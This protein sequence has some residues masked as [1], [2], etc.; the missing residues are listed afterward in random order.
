V[1]LR[2]AFP[3]NLEWRSLRQELRGGS[4]LDIP[5]RFY[6]NADEYGRNRINI[7]FDFR[8]NIGY[9]IFHRDRRFYFN[10]RFR[11]LHNLSVDF[12]R[13]VRKCS[14]LVCV[15]ILDEYCHKFCDHWDNYN[16]NNDYWR[17][18]FHYCNGDEF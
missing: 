1:D 17:G 9:D 12:N 5:P 3:F 8:L 10:E 14:N 15:G 6:C 11:E 4:M 13:R 7:D 2:C 16:A 18:H